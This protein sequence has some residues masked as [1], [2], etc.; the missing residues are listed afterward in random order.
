ML[1]FPEIKGSLRV[2]VG[3]ADSSSNWALFALRMIGF[4]L[5]VEGLVKGLE[6]KGSETDEH[7]DVSP[8]CCRTALSPSEPYL[9]CPKGRELPRSSCLAY[10]GFC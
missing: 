7:L 6:A 3:R 5:R 10:L 1:G 8:V 9:L 4:R 2:A